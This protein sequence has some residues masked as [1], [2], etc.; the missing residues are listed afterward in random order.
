MAEDGVEAL[1]V[2]DTPENIFYREI[3]IERA[4]VHCIP[5]IYPYIDDAAAGGLIAYTGDLK[6]M[7]RICVD[8]I[9]R[10]FAGA[11]PAILPF[12]QPTRLGLTINLK[13]A[14]ALGLTIPEAV[15]ARADEVIE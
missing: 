7:A 8:N 14:R 13:T 10:I 9:V 5:A 4:R 15:L 11:S 6:D 2:S 1:I 12:Q 3:I